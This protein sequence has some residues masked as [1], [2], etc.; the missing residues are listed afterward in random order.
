[1]VDLVGGLEVRERELRELV[2]AV[3]VLTDGCIVD[4]EERERPGIEHPCREGAALEE[5]AVPR[6][7]SREAAL[8]DPQASWIHRHAQVHDRKSTH[9]LRIAHRGRYRPSSSPLEA[10]T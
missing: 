2:A 10:R 5:R 9:S 3:T 7:R 6:L 4:L 8:G 1:M